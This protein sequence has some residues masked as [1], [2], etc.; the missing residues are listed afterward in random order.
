MQS[1]AVCSGGFA[2]TNKK[3]SLPFEDIQ[4]M[5][6]VQ[7][8]PVKRVCI[9]DLSEETNKNTSTDLTHVGNPDEIS[10]QYLKAKERLE[11]AGRPQNDCP[12]FIQANKA[13]GCNSEKH[14]HLQ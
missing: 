12:S 3:R 10:K 9:T 2:S 8:E 5:S 6:L 1:T 11:S 4:P 14:S 7:S 13:G